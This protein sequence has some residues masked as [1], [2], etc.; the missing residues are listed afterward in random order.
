MNKKHLVC[1]LAALAGLSAAPVF[2]TEH[3]G[4]IY[5]GLTGSGRIS[6][7]ELGDNSLG[8]NSSLGYR[9]GALGVEGGYTSFGTFKDQSLAGS[10]TV[11][12]DAK[13]D[14]WNAGIN[15][16]H[17]LSAKWSVQGR[18]GLFAWNADGHVA[19]GASRVAYSDSGRDWY[20]GASIDYKRTKR[21]S[22]GL[23]YARYKLGDADIDLWG[24]HSEFRFGAK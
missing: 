8:S 6:Q 1:A 2:A 10:G 12:I 3:K 17:D 4:W 15:L 5:N 16:N 23:G 24:L 22:I 18:V 14:G 21:S 13:A 11:E 19:D 9:W 20:V 7:G